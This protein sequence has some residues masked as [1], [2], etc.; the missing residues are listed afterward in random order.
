MTI[1]LYFFHYQCCRVAY[2][3]TDVISNIQHHCSSFCMSL[4]VNGSTY[5]T[6]WNT[7]T[8]HK[9]QLTCIVFFKAYNM[10]L[11]TVLSMKNSVE[12]AQHVQINVRR[13]TGANALQRPKN[14][15]QLH[16]PWAPTSAP[17]QPCASLFSVPRFPLSFELLAAVFYCSFVYPALLVNA[18]HVMSSWWDVSSFGYVLAN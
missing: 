5:C 3:K 7:K 18:A 17:S 14:T 2:C 13:Q 1:K 8:I 6:Y 16:N 9:L 10:T 11:A 15:Q 12:M 4:F